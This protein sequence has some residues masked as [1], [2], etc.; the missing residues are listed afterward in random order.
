MRRPMLDRA[1]K[2]SLPTPTTAQERAPAIRP[3]IMSLLPRGLDFFRDR[4]LTR[5]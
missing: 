4:D 5:S 1:A 2:V 3:L